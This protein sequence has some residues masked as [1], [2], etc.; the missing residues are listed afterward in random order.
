LLWIQIV[1]RLAV[2]IIPFRSIGALSFGDS[3]QI[4]RKKLASTYSTFEKVV[5]ENETD[6]FDDLGLHLYYSDT[7]H[8]EFVE[9]FDPAEVVFSGI[10]FLGR[11]LDSVTSD[12]ESLGFSPTKSDVGVR[13]ER[14]GIALTA[15]SGIVEGVAAHRKD[16][17]DQ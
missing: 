10:N 14:A 7:G 4:A 12:M 17:Y 5:G 9:A 3:R 6:S 2:E 8:L 11:D 13:F 16:Y 1:R 15:P